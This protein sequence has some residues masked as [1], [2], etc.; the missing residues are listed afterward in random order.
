MRLT[1]LKCGHQMEVATG[2]NDLHL[3]C[4]CGQDYSSPDVFN[5][6]ICP[7]ERAAER[8]RS[9]AFRAAGLVK[10]MGGFALGVALLG[11]LFFPIALIGAAVG[12]YTLTM[13]RGPLARYSGRRSAWAAVAVGVAVFAGEGSLFVTIVRARQIQKLE[14]TQQSVSEDLR[15]L[16][17]AERLY[18]AT[19]DT[20]G[21]FRELAFKAPSGRYTLYLGADESLAAV[22]DGEEI[23]DPLPA[24]LEP[25]L[26]ESSFT[27]VAV[28]NL[29]GDDFV[30]IWL[31]SD[32]GDITHVANDANDQLS[33]L[34][35]PQGA[36]PASAPVAQPVGEEKTPSPTT[37]TAAT[38]VGEAPKEGKEDAATTERAPARRTPKEADERV[39]PPA[40]DEPAPERPASEP[41]AAEPTAA[42]PPPE[43]DS[44]TPASDH[45]APE[46][47]EPAPAPPVENPPPSEPVAPENAANP[48]NE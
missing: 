9:R 38:A 12:I 2:A 17:R 40:R 43:I 26:S 44:A 4:V 41:A 47:P 32:L 7:N 36:V 3:R 30:D 29:D 46:A 10:N 48:T 42:M 21:S 24:V 27:A 22:R 6:G 45:A 11:V 8:L 34:T 13:L 14:T 5:T 31:L 15:A 28:A 33:T 1:C 20:Y 19:R 39:E 16:L 35:P 37:E 25:G 18:R 23:V